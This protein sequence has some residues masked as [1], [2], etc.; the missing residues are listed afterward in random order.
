V[1]RA[2]LVLTRVARSLR[3]RYSRL[4][5]EA[6]YLEA[7][8]PDVQRGID[9]CVTQ[10][11]RRILFVPYFLYLGGHVGQDLPKEIT[12]ARRRHPGLEIRIAGHLG[13]DRRLVSLVG[14]RIR[15][16]LRRGRWV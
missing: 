10:G 2:N 16:G 11:A 1:R 13:F 5:V 12:R 6:C 9:R 15:S 3:R 4:V 14:D 7:A 8:D